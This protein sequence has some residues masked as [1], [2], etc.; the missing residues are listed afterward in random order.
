MKL[1]KLLMLAAAVTAGLP[2]QTVY[3]PVNAPYAQSL[4]IATKNAHPEL[5]KLGLHAMPPGEHVYAIIANAIPSKIGKE[6]SATDLSVVTSRKPFAKIDEK[7][8]FYDLRFPISD[9][10]DNFIGFTVMEI[11][12]TA[13]TDLNDA[14]AKGTV[15]R[16]ELQKKIP[17]HDQL[18]QATDAPAVVMPSMDY[19]AAIQGRF[20]HFAVDAEHNRLFSTAEDSHAVV[21]FD[22]VNG[23][24]IKSI[25]GLVRPHAILYRADLNRI[26]LTDGGDGRLKVFDGSSYEQVGSVQLEKDADSIGYDLTTKYLYI[27][28]GGKDAGKPYSFVSIVDT[29]SNTKVADIRI[30]SNTLEAMALDTFRPR[31][32]VNDNAQNKVTVIDRLNRKVLASW[33]LTMG[34]LNVAM[35]LDEQRQRLFIGCRS[36]QI[37]VLDS[38]TG[39]ELQA[40]PITKGIDDLQFDPASKRLYAIGDGTVD[41][42]QEADA[43][44]YHLLGN[45]PVGAGAKTGTIVPSMNR[46]FAAVP[47]SSSSP[48]K[49]G[50]LQ[51]VNL[52]IAASTSA[53]ERVSLNAPQALRL[54]LETM[55]AH[56]DLRKMGIHAIPPGGKDSVIVA[57]A[58]TMRVGYKSSQGDLDAVKDGNTY[59]V[60]RDDGSFFNAKLPLKDASGHVIG[61][62]VMEIPFTSAPT[63]EQAIHEAEAIRAEVAAKIPDYEWLFMN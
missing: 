10:S 35:G 33:P 13:A 59:C 43:D 25:A 24:E 52:P 4:V 56:P 36:G 48:A 5:Q 32:Y 2:A 46:Y 22:L 14:L 8:K 3:V 40:L 23:T 61:I 16:D 11:P 17:G 15:V 29:S 27:D 18:F 51:P 60:K 44:H 1:F 47:A 45:I 26:Y 63:Q 42:Y 30:D 37:V 57:N 19:A 7:G 58:N 50:I 62:L 34:K 12:F 53:E 6:S 49:V 28:N 54:D 31:M 41:I 20:D 38:N 55:S 39:K 9:A 21:V